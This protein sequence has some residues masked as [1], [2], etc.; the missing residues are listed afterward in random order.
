MGVATE[1]DQVVGELRH[2]GRD[3][4]VV[5]PSPGGRRPVYVRLSSLAELSVLSG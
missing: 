1:L 4:A 2:G 5:H 3:V